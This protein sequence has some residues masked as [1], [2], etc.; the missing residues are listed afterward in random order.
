MVQ[1]LVP[2]GKKFYSRKKSRAVIQHVGDVS[3]LSMCE[4]SL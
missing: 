3:L 1:I 2:L 4:K